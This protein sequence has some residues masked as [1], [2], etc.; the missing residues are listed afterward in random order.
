[1][2]PVA[3]AQLTRDGHVDVRAWIEMAFFVDRAGTFITV[4]HVIG[5]VRKRSGSD[6]RLS[7]VTIHGS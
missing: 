1:M 6:V 5:A 7:H 2:V 3:C 4:E